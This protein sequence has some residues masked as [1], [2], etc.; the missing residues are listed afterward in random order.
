[1]RATRRRAYRDYYDD[2]LRELVGEKARAIIERYGYS[3]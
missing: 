3:F 2:E 1:V